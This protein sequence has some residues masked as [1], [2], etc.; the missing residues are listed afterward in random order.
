MSKGILS[1]IRSEPYGRCLKLENGIIE[2]LATLDYGPRIMHFSLKEQRNVLCDKDG[3][4]QPTLGGEEWHIRGG[5][6]LW[7]SPE[8]YPRTYIA[9]NRP[10]NYEKVPNGV[11][12]IQQTEEWVQIQKE[13]EITL[14]PGSHRVRIEHRLTNKNA[15]TVE[16]SAWGVTLLA[17][18][19]TQI[20]PMPTRQTGLLPN[21]VF[22]LWPYSSMQDSRI[23][24]GDKYIFLKQQPEI[25]QPFKLGLGNEEGWAAYLNQD[26]LFIK[27]HSHQCKATY[28]DYGMSYETY[29]AD[30]M[31]EMESLSPVTRLEPETVLIHEEVWE[32]YGNISI[33]DWKESAV[34]ECLRHY[35]K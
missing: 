22:A 23:T 12:L 21:R 11:K 24:W 7:H 29:I 26:Q 14:E 31:V 18:G 25:K 35:I 15:W 2:L 19:G 27:R 3:F 34:E 16:L 9:D 8:Q 33:D 6:R 13:I 32:L 28:P 5:H 30:Y 1:E 10:V 20:I 4:S 17:P